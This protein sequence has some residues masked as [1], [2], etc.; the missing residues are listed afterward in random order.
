[1]TSRK[2]RRCLQLIGL[3]VL[4][5][6]FFSQNSIEPYFEQRQLDE[7]LTDAYYGGEV[8]ITTIESERDRFWAGGN[9]YK[10]VANLIGT[11]NRKPVVDG[12]EYVMERLDTGE[13]LKLAIDPKS[14]LVS[15]LGQHPVLVDRNISFA[16]TE[17]TTR[18]TVN[19]ELTRIQNYLRI[20][21]SYRQLISEPASPVTVAVVD[22]GFAD[23]SE[24]CHERSQINTAELN[25]KPGT[26]DDENGYVDDICGWNFVEGKA[27]VGDL[28]GHG[29]HLTGLVLALSNS[30]ILPIQALD[31]D[32]RVDLERLLKSLNYTIAQLEAGDVLNLSIG[33]KA[34]SA[35]L[36]KL[37]AEASEKGIHI[38]ASAGNLSE[39]EVL[40][41]AAYSSVIAAGA[42]NQSGYKA[43]YSNYG[44]EVELSF[45]GDALSLHN[46]RNNYLVLKEGTSQSAAA[47]S[48]IIATSQ[49]YLPE[50]G[51]TDLVNFLQSNG[52]E[53]DK[54]QLGYLVT[55]KDLAELLQPQPAVISSGN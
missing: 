37:L 46:E 8:E 34:D 51:R 10:F 44:P 30:K 14:D 16:A 42:T 43:R 7:L 15:R 25:G 50:F 47:I 9:N 28:N 26:D 31:A 32:N 23:T 35:I 55:L 45:Q 38:V 13:L 12:E 41:P 52:L 24:G 22:S 20:P 2:F 3:L 39:N 48:A 49:S 11:P 19:T 1:M 18:A 27:Q 36:K 21:N 29:T 33:A 54:N 53:R 6:I 4:T 17:A 40:K 5:A